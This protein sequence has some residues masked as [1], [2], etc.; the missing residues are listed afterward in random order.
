MIGARKISR[1]SARR[2]FVPDAP[3]T[4]HDLDQFFD[5][6]TLPENGLN[7]SD[8]AI[9]HGE[10]FKTWVSKKGSVFT[11]LTY[12]GAQNQRTGIG[13]PK[14]YDTAMGKCV[15]TLNVNDVRW[16]RS[17]FSSIP[18][19]YT[20]MFVY[21][22]LIAAT[23]ESL[24]KT[25]GGGANYRDVNGNNVAY[26]TNTGS[27]G[28]ATS[29]VPDY[30]KIHYVI[31]KYDSG[32]E[33]IIIDGTERYSSGT[34]GTDALVDFRIGVNSNQMNALHFGYWVKEGALSAGEES[35]I[36]TI[37]NEVFDINSLNP[38]GLDFDNTHLLTGEWNAITKKFYF[39]KD[40][41]T[42]KATFPVGTTYRWI[43]AGNLSSPSFATEDFITEADFSDVGSPPGD[44]TGDELTRADYNLLF[45]NNDGTD[46]VIL[47]GEVYLPDLPFSLEFKWI[48]DNIA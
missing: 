43:E 21:M 35:A 15:H 25:G 7:F 26:D 27:N 1:R 33:S 37:M 40:G 20:I 23:N 34:I 28:V 13:R 42:S 47:I 18:Q 17:P 22:P 48:R 31:L 3:I 39:S 11:G 44:A 10:E 9:S 5:H 6:I 30:N 8:A 45:P 46:D 4:I 36:D 32:N 41:G 2:G 14:Y 16:D 24:F 12:A 38:G 29:P 19:P